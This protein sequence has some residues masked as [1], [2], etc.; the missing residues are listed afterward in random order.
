MKNQKRFANQVCRGTRRATRKIPEQNNQK[1]E[2]KYQMKYAVA[3][4]G[5]HDGLTRAR[6]P[7]AKA[8]SIKYVV[9]ASRMLREAAFVQIARDEATR[10]TTR[11]KRLQRA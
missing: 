1:R 8:F 9:E 6:Q 5:P 11:T 3:R 10:R 7:Q 4:V 2:K